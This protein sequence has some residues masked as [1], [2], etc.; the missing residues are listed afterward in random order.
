ME[1]D[2]VLNLRLSRAT[3]D[4]LD[5]AAAHHMRSKSG[6]A[7]WVLAQWLA[8]EGFMPAPATPRATRKA[9]R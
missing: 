3:K 5:R 1:R 9:K 2:A 6:M 7:A 4:A 8:A